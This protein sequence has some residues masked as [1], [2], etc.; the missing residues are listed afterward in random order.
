MGKLTSKLIL[1]IITFGLFWPTALARENVTNWYIKDFISDIQVNKDSR[2]LISEKI[3]ADCGQCVGKHGIF[4]ILPT[5]LA[6]DTGET[7]QMPVELVSITDFNGTPLN[8][9]VSKNRGDHTITWKI[10]DPN[11]TVQGINN[12][13][14]TYR[15]K[16]TIGFT[17]SQFD[18]LYWNLLGNFWDLEI[19]KFT[20]NIYFPSE[21]SQNNT[22]TNLY[23]GQYGQKDAGLAQSRWTQNSVLQIQS[24]RPLSTR[25]GITVSVT[26]PKNIFTPYQPSPWEK[27]G[28]YLFLLIPALVLYFCYRLWSRYGRDPKGNPTIVPEFDIPNNLP[29]LELGLIY[30]DGVFK[31]SYLSAAIINLATKGLILIEKIEKQGIFGHEDY[32]IK[33]L[34]SNRKVVAP[35]EQRLLDE[36]FAQSAKTRNILISD[37]K[38]K[39]YKSA[40]ILKRDVTKDLQQKR[41]LDLGGRRLKYLLIGTAGLLVFGSFFLGQLP[42]MG[43]VSLIITAFIS[44]IFSFIMPRRTVEGLAV[45][46]KIMGFKLYMETAERYRQN[47]FEKENIF[48]KFLPYAMVFGLTTLWIE[49]MKQIYGQEYFA[50]YHPVWFVGGSLGAFDTQSFNSAITDLSSNM[51]ATLSSSPSSGSGAGGGG[52][53]GGGG[54]GGGGG[55]W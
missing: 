15:V 13:K 1:L 29:P 44:I 46:K 45:W 42:L 52:F 49:K 3:T 5:Q 51:A 16:N 14:I 48:E 32:K 19:D 10:G 27:Y 8:Y 11:N 24:L 36:L 21:I 54:G 31:S 17:N 2:L 18:E 28:P 25:Q 6:L 34:D 4:R 7:I 50:T 33:L 40:D 43:R 38:N 55:G 20:A 12:Y 9:S 37:L 39:F 22:Q 53:S 41:L 47:F 35:S 30:S 23:T 26:L